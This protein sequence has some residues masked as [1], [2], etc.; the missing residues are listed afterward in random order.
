MKI[1]PPTYFLILLFLSILFHFVFPI[2]KIIPSPYNH[3]GWVFII[4]GI[5]LN[6]W[7]DNLFKKHKTTVEP[8]KKSQKLVL[9]GPF[10]ISRNPMYLGMVLILIGTSVILRSLIT[11][12]FPI[13]FIIIIETIFIPIEEKDMEKVFRK[14][15]Q[16]YKNKIR[17]WI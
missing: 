1:K 14:E 15:Y 13:V 8:G 12:L 11:F 16:N 4:I 5:T 10:K 6:I 7:A 3:L 2:K 9:E 17:R